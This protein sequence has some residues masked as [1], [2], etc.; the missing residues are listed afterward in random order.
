MLAAL[1]Q[2][3]TQQAWLWH[4]VCTALGLVFATVLLG[5][6]WRQTSDPWSMRHHSY[7]QGPGLLLAGQLD[8]CN[9]AS[10]LSANAPSTAGTSSARSIALAEA[11][12]AA[13][14]VA[15]AAMLGLDLYLHQQ[16]RTVSRAPA[17]STAQSVPAGIVGIAVNLAMYWLQAI[18]HASTW[19]EDTLVSCRY[20][21]TVQVTSKTLKL[22]QAEAVQYLWLAVVPLGYSVLVL[23]VIQSLSSIDQEV[24]CLP[25]A[26]QRCCRKHCQVVLADLQLLKMKDSMYDHKTA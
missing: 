14:L 20:S 5:C 7:F 4:L 15:S 25:F 2:S 26:Q 3:R 10:G 21:K 1:Q 18:W 6:A 24:S 13:V 16:S 19:Q 12:S 9:G 8:C 22:M 17:S 11:G 23:Y